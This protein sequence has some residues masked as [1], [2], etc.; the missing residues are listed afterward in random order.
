MLWLLAVPFAGPVIAADPPV[1]ES[2][3]VDPDTSTVTEGT[4]V[5]LTATVFDQY[6]N[7]FSGTGTNTQVRFYFVLG[8]PND[9]HGGLAPT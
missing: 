2:L 9:P 7:V 4:T 6:G 8:S 1:L 3:D 5:V